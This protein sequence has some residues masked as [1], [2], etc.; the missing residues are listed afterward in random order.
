[1]D[2][3]KRRLKLATARPW[4]Q[5]HRLRP[6][7]LRDLLSPHVSLLLSSLL[8]AASQ[9]Y[10]THLAFFRWW[11]TAAHSRWMRARYGLSNR[12]GLIRNLRGCHCKKRRSFV[13]P[14]VLCDRVGR[15]H[16]G[17]SDLLASGLNPATA[18]IGPTANTARQTSEGSTCCCCCCCCDLKVTSLGEL[19]GCSDVRGAETHL[20]IGDVSCAR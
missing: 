3:L 10:S 4:G 18:T 19:Q 6:H 8:Q 9:L 15:Q 5:L 11:T 20:Q 7:H 17:Q 12:G 13:V 16:L 1:M 2:V 14:C